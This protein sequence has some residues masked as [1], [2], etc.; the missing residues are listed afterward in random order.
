MKVKTNDYVVVH[1]DSLKRKV[2]GK[3]I[4]DSVRNDERI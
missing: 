1:S 4:D 3:V 2:V